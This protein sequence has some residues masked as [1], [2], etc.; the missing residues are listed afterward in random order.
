MRSWI[1]CLSVIPV[2]SIKNWKSSCDDMPGRRSAC[3]P[4][5]CENDK[6]GIQ[7]GNEMGR[8]VQFAQN[9]RVYSGLSSVRN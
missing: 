9:R 4:T 3:G 7:V 1:S 2:A 5:H 6:V 8:F